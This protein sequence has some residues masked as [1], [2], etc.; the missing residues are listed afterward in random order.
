M[1]TALRNCM[2]WGNI[3]MHL[4]GAEDLK[5]EGYPYDW[6]ANAW[7]A[8]GRRRTKHK[9]R[10][11]HKRKSQKLKRARVLNDVGEDELG[12]FSDPASDFGSGSGPSSSSLDTV[13]DTSSG[14][15]CDSDTN[16]SEADIAF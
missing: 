7:A 4:I 15:G 16:T 6:V 14:S 11:P 12:E 2:S 3:R 8:K 9:K 5:A 10:A 1:V 13:S